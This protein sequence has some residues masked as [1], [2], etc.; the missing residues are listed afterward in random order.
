VSEYTIGEEIKEEYEEKEQ[1]L[2]SNFTGICNKLN[3]PNLSPEKKKRLE[4]NLEYVRKAIND[5]HE[6][7]FL[8]GRS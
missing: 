6:N 8:I 4:E 7:I 2:Q 3:K 1:R 5:C